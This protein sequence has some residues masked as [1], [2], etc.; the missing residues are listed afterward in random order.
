M[1]KRWP[2]NVKDIMFAF[3]VEFIC[4]ATASLFKFKQYCNSTSKLSGSSSVTKSTDK[5]FIEP[6]AVDFNSDERVFTQDNTETGLTENLGSTCTN[7]IDK[8]SHGTCTN[9]IDKESHGT[10]TNSLDGQLH[11]THFQL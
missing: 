11:R 10:C 4:L 1:Y 8:E 3:L 6:A 2:L 5:I 9:S 7:S